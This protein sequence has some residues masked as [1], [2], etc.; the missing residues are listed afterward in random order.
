MS[1]PDADRLAAT[2][3]VNHHAQLAD[4]LTG[5]VQRL[6]DAA[7][8]GDPD[9]AQSRR[10]ALLD[11]LLTELLPHAAAEEAAMYPAAAELPAGKLLVDGMLAE[12][13]AIAAAVAELS[14]AGTAVD[15]AAAARAL[16]ALFEVHLAKENELILP[17]L[18]AAEQVSVAG[19]LDGMHDLLGGGD[20]SHGGHS[21]GTRSHG[22]DADADPDDY[23]DGGGGCGGGGGSCGCGGDSGSAEAPAPVF[24]V[25][26]RLDVRAL[27]HGERH[28]RVL[29]ALD[30][31]P[32]D[33]ALVLVAPHAP[34]PLLAEI[35]SH[36]AGLID[37]EWL[38]EGPEVW[39]VRLHRQPTT[40]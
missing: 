23:L 20:H 37:A 28:A 15:A 2:A 1:Q 11:W 24:T 18:L 3:V 19:L 16:S 21:H 8:G 17:L 26:A 38:Q 39:Q 34:R 30:A 35:D 25:D 29:A 12:H 9:L 13:Q 10:E 14:D 6:R 7:V 33:G 5:H 4:E 22:D 31:L 32:A 27:P 40:V 36:Y